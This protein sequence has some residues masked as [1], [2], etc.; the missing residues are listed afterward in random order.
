MAF[1]IYFFVF[2]ILNICPKPIAKNHHKI[3][4]PVNPVNP[5]SL[6]SPV[7]SVTLIPSVPAVRLS[8]LSRQICQSRQSRQSRRACQFQDPTGAGSYTLVVI[9]THLKCG[10]NVNQFQLVMHFV[11]ISTVCETSQLVGNLAEESEKKQQRAVLKK[12]REK[13]TDEDL[14]RSVM[15]VFTESDLRKSIR[16]ISSPYKLLRYNEENFHF[17]PIQKIKIDGRQN[18]AAYISI[19]EWFHL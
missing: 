2:P 12:I 4:S 13:S 14:I 15:G 9:Y 18:N 5:V 11:P 6:A 1:C 7:P 3:V 10:N 8:L 17:V 16:L 19:K